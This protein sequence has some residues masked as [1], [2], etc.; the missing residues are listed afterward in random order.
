M[1]S[2]LLACMLLV[3]HVTA[4]GAEVIRYPRPEG[5]DDH[6]MDYAVQLLRLAVSKVGTEYRL[7]MNQVA[8]NQD[9]GALEIEAGR[10]IDIS[11]LPTSAE[12]E[13]RLLPIRI[14]ITK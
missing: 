13:A 11:A 12:R 5:E 4:M 14:P 7:Q 8:M 2:R 3:W 1:M 6:R 9:R 10:E